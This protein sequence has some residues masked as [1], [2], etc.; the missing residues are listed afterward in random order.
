MQ[1]QIAPSEGRF[2][3]RGDNESDNVPPIDVP[4]V[5]DVSEGCGSATETRKAGRT[6]NEKV[7]RV[8]SPDGSFDLVHLDAN[9]GIRLEWNGED[10]EVVKT[11]LGDD[12]SL[13]VTLRDVVPKR[14][15]G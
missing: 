13:K 10:Y 9:V 8:I 6:L 5:C 12:G 3:R 1:S 2:L 11:E 15:G 14:F 4:V 7:M